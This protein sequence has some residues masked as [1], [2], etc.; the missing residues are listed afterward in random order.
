[1]IEIVRIPEDRKP[2]LAG[3]GGKAR[4]LLEKE[5]KTSIDISDEVRITGDDPLL[6]L[7]AR[8]IVQAVGRG[9]EP[10]KAMRIVHD[11]AELRV[12]SMTGERLKKRQRLFARVIGRQG[13]CK[14]KIEQETGADI[15]IHGKTLAL[16]GTRDE[17]GPAVSAVEELLSGKTHAYAYKK[18][19]IR[20][21]HS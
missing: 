20:K 7:K 17:L 1:M 15:V 18:M 8:D 3:R 10:K 19:H 2:V 6:V 5:T 16:I 21:E 4:V 13:R 12:I 9:F 11:D 14:K